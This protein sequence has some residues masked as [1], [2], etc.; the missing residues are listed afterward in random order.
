MARFLEVAAKEKRALNWDG[1]RDEPYP[2]CF[3]YDMTKLPMK[4]VDDNTYDGVYS[5]HFIEHLTREEGIAYFKEMLRIMKPGGVVRTVWP[6]MDFVDWLRSDQDLTNHEFVQ[7]YYK[8]YIVKHKF[9]PAGTE[10][11]SLQ[12]QC[13]EGLMWQKGEHKH[14]WYRNE[15][16]DM[17]K[18]LGYKLVR[19]RNYMQSGVN[20]FKNIDTPGNIRALHSAVV[21]ATKPW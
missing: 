19:E 21:E 20:E 12:E 5:E 14:L 18:D 16:I 7:H 17:L 2:G 4:G 15:M 6:P 10:H 13:A 8:F 3:V 1:V 9:A 11:L